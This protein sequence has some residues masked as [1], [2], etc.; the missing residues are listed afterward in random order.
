[1]NADELESSIL[2]FL[3]QELRIWE[4]VE[5]DTELV[6]T[7]IVDSAGLVQLATHL[8]RTLDLSIPDHEINVDN[9]DSIAMILEYV[10]RKLGS[11]A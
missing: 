11:R 5:R 7:G 2:S 8:E 3:R 4:N 6:S 9:F 1:M 10:E